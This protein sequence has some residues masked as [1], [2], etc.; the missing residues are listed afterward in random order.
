MT[1]AERRA[2]HK[3]FSTSKGKIARRGQRLRYRA[4][5]RGRLN[6]I[7]AKRRY[8][9]KLARQRRRERRERAAELRRLIRIGRAVVKLVQVSL[10]QRR[11]PPMSR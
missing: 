2:R 10:R 7:L 9:A 4:T 3:Y 6:L 8:N 5:P 1:N 11:R